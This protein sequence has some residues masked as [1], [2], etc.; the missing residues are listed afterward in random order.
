[1]HISGLCF[2]HEKKTRKTVYEIIEAKFQFK[3]V[4]FISFITVTPH[5]N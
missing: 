4:H 3:S 1:M 5:E 2:K